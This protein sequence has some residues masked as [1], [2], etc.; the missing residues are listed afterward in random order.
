MVFDRPRPPRIIVGLVVVIL[1]LSLAVAIDAREGGDLVFLLGLSSSRVWHGELWRLVTWPFIAV[2]PWSLVFG[3]VTVYVCGSDLVSAW[4]TRPFARYVAAALLIAGG[5]ATLVSLVMPSV[6]HRLY[7]G[8]WALDDALVIAWALQFPLRLVRIWF[9]LE[10]RG[11]MLVHAVTGLTVLV[12]IYAG[13]SAVLPELLASAVALTYMDGW[14]RLA[15][16][17]PAPAPPPRPR[18]RGPYR[19]PDD[20]PPPN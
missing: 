4:G 15:A 3:C 5:G 12:A 20:A 8:C 6:D 17:R 7:L 18:P 2:G 16:P 19:V 11:R 14:P 13:V 9:V 10:L 1:V